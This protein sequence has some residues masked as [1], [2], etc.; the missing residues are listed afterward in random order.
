[1][2]EGWYR[3]GPINP[4]DTI[5]CEQKLF[6]VKNEIIN[7]DS[8][9]K[10]THV[11]AL[12]WY[13][14]ILGSSFTE[15]VLKDQSNTQ[16]DIS[17]KRFRP[18]HLIR[19]FSLTLMS[20]YDH[21]IIPE[22]KTGALSKSNFSNQRS[23]QIFYGPSGSKSSQSHLNP[24]RSVELV[25]DFQPQIDQGSPWCN[26]PI[27]I[28]PKRSIEIFFT[29][30]YIKLHVEILTIKCVFKVKSDL[31]LVSYS[32]LTLAGPF[33]VKLSIQSLPKSNIIN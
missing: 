12:K 17:R 16:K 22:Y 3:V 19:N 33:K 21:S 13:D 32:S 5:Q 20:I 11:A 2:I 31:I 29:F 7:P 6:L 30:V 15:F 23:N 25:T 10:L 28:I 14:C 26:D 24:S 18:V 4:C 8:R 9:R 27:K 1:M